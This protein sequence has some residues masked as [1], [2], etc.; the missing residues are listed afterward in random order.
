MCGMESRLEEG[1]GWRLPSLSYTDGLVLCGESEED[2]KVNADKSK[3]M[4]LC[5]EDGL[6]CEALVNGMWLDQMAEFKYLGYI[7]GESGGAD[8]IEFC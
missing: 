6:V 4:V 1:R 3:L 2:L 7:L 5:E 8:S